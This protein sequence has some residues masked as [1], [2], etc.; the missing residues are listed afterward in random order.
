MAQ[1]ELVLGAKLGSG[2]FGT[3][4]KGAWGVRTVAVKK[5]SISESESTK[6]AIQ[7]EIRLLQKLQDRHIIQFYGATFHEDRLV[8]IMEYA[9]CG[10]LT[11]VIEERQQKPK[12][13]LQKQQQQQQQL[14]QQPLAPLDWPTKS[15]IA[16][17]IALGLAYIHSMMILHQD[18]KSDNVLLTRHM[19]VRLCDFGMSTVK[20]TSASRV[21]A[22]VMKGTVGWMA[23]EILAKRPQYST[24]SDIYALGMVMWEM[25]ANCTTPFKEHRDNLVIMSLVKSG[26]REDLPDDTPADYR[27]WVERCWEQDPHKRPEAAD[28]FSEPLT[29]NISADVTATSISTPPTTPILAAA[30]NISRQA[31]PGLTAHTLAQRARTRQASNASPTGL[32]LNGRSNNNYNNTNHTS[33]PA[34]ESREFAALKPLAIKDDTEAQMALAR[35]YERG[36]GIPKDDAKAFAWYHQAARLGHLQAQFRVGE[37]F[38]DGVGTR[39]ND[40]QAASWFQKAVDQGLVVAEIALGAMYLD[41]QGVEQSDET[42]VLWFRKASELGG[43]AEAMFRLGRMYEDGRGVEQNDLE[44]AEWYLKAAEK[45]HKDAQRRWLDVWTR[46]RTR[47]LQD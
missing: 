18:L 22:D 5:F 23:P 1:P 26:E 46:S 36:D 43:D 27:R 33:T 10:S 19:E 15:R 14:Q 17:E 44:A 13:Q 20:T 4:Y 45:G 41:G 35:M 21:S 3:V 31:S 38:R 6:G 30:Q 39:K 2:G 42:A 40:R 7:H 12:T 47:T 25:A 28:M 29:N 34:H 11:R 9:E 37:M 24:K 32:S 16:R 8:V